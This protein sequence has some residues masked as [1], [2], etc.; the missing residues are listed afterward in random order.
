MPKAKVAITLEARLLKA[1]DAR[2]K[3]REF[4]SRSSAIEAAL[5]AQERLGVKAKRDADY[6]AMLARLDPVEEVAFA[7]ERY[8][9]EVFG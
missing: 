2:V 9:G 7:E 5:R 8:K 1:I 4:P 3:R 6:L